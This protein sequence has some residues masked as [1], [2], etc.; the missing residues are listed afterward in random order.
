[1]ESLITRRKHL[2]ILSVLVFTLLMMSFMGNNVVADVREEPVAQQEITTAVTQLISVI[3]QGY[4]HERQGEKAVEV[5][6]QALNSGEFNGHFTYRRLKIKLES[7]LFEVTKDANFELHFRSGLSQPSDDIEGALPGAIQAR[8][9]ENNTGY[10]AVD[11]DFVDDVWLAEFDNAMAGLSGSSALII[12]LRSAGMSSM[13]FSQHFLSY[14]LP[15]GQLLSDVS[16]AHEQRVELH[17]KKIEHPVIQDVAVFIV[18]SPFVAGAWEFVAYTLQQTD[19]AIIVGNPTMGLG[20][21][22]IT[23]PLSEHLSIEMAYAQIINPKTH[24]NWQ[25]EGVVPDIYCDAKEAVA[26]SLLLSDHEVPTN[27]D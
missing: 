22:T 18:T 20:Y 10:L 26:A 16:F 25:G 27:C 7:M 12:D 2:K 14:F 1:M 6:T 23:K 8:I 17:S 11:G 9:L 19:R 4:I 21:M 3:K 5:L 13:A 24:D 15:S